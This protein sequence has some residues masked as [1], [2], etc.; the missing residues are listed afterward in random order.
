MKATLINNAGD[1]AGDQQKPLRELSSLATIQKHF[2]LNI[3][4]YIYL[5]AAFLRKFSEVEKLVV[6][7]ISSSAARVPYECWSLYCANRAARRIVLGV[8]AK[9]EVL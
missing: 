3:G 5:T 9:E 2:C 4:S 7:N 6:V 1:T 8:L